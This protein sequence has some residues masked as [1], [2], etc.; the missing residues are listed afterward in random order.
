MSELKIH[1][2]VGPK[3]QPKY[4]IFDRDDE[5]IPFQK[6]KPFLQIITTI[7]CMILAIVAI[8]YDEIQDGDISFTPGSSWLPTKVDYDCGWKTLRFTSYYGNGN[9]MTESYEYNSQLCDVNEDIYNNAFCSEMKK[10]GLAWLIC[11]IFGIIFN[12]I[13]VFFIYR[14]GKASLIHF[15]LLFLSL[16]MYFVATFN[17]M[18]NDKCSDIE[19]NTS[20]NALYDTKIGTSLV[21]L[22][23]VI[24][25]S[26]IN[27]L[28][29][30]IYI[31]SYYFY[32]ND[33][34]DDD[35]NI[36]QPVLLHHMAK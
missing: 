27:F 5:M 35:N 28:L 13:S 11:I 20:E 22:F 3:F 17:W 15:T 19:Q 14:F 21:L 2:N 34:D 6:T 10:N 16:L 18:A 31:I 4:V 12:F 1:E 32:K 29:S 25:L 23:I 30:S 7:I 24:G 8:S 26:S 33:N 36:N 9:H